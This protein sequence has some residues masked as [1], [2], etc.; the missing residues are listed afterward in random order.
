[1]AKCP[2]C[3]KHLSSLNIESVLSTDPSRITYTTAIYSCSLCQKI[4]SAQIDPITIKEEML[5][6]ITNRRS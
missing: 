6:I 3:E 1:M 2:Y 4:I 5:D